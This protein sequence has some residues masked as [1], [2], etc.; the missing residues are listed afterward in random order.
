MLPPQYIRSPRRPHVC[1]KMGN[2]ACPSAAQLLA[3]VR[4]P[5]EAPY[6]QASLLLLPASLAI[7]PQYCSAAAQ[8]ISFINDAW[9]GTRSTDRNLYVNG[10]DY[11]GQPSAK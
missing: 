4:S 3:S 5:T 8:V 1:R 2:S 11:D 7:Q 6:G 10:V 9:G